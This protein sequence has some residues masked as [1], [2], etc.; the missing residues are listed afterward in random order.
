MSITVKTRTI[1]NDYFGQIKAFQMLNTFEVARKIA[2]SENHKWT[3]DGNDIYCLTVLF[4][5]QT[6]TGKSST[7]NKLAEGD[8]M[9][10]NA[11]SCCTKEMNSLDFEICQ[12]LYF[13][14]CDMP[15]IGEGNEEDE[16]YR[17]WYEEMYWYSDCVVYVLRADQ[18]SY[19]LDIQE[20][21][22]L[23]NMGYSKLLLAINYTDRIE[24]TEDES[25]YS[26]EQNLKMKIKDVSRI[27]NVPESK[28][29]PYSAKKEINLWKLQDTI[30]ERVFLN[31]K[32]YEK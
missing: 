15:G 31:L 28:I 18:R 21:N 25:Y 1:S 29:V 32:R 17:Q 22:K 9:E 27:F 19:S 5:G 2:Y 6:G 12:N 13:C 3:K 20:F 4:I 23:R 26:H 16:V 8:F 30:T 7:I 11:Y 14:L 24:P 10:T